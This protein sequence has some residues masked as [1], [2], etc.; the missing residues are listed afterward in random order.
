MKKIILF[1]LDDTVLIDIPILVES[2]IV[3]SKYAEEKFNVNSEKLQESVRQHAEKLWRQMPTYQYC[4]NIGTSSGEGLWGEYIGED[5]NLQKLRSLIKNYRI[6]AWHKSL[7]DFNINNKE[8]AKE[9][10]EK[11]PQERRKRSR[12]FSDALEVLSSLK[13]NYR[14]GLLTNGA[15][16]LQWKKIK[17]SKLEPFFDQIIISGEY[18][19]GKPDK[20]IFDIALE[21]FKAKKENAVMVGNSLSRDILGARNAEIKS[22]WIKREFAFSAAADSAGKDENE[23]VEPDAVIANLSELPSALKKLEF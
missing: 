2:L 16:D 14:L 11:F 9:L 8:F 17:G 12:L 3:V 15:P 19:V 6:N 13:Q 18:G 7:L 5:K 22:I 21:K 23:K 10:A 1:D 4:L 20:K